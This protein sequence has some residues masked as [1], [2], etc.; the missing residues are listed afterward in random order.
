MNNEAMVHAL[1]HGK[2]HAEAARIADVSERTISRRLQDPA[3]AARVDE[4]R[5]EVVS[6]AGAQLAGLFPRA[7]AT[8][9]DL[10]DDKDS[11]TRLGAAQLVFKSGLVFREQVEIE[12]RLRALET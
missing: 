4:A 6:A 10:L 1:A 9:A 11:R 3:F 8:L 7:I 12:D 2:T 5:A